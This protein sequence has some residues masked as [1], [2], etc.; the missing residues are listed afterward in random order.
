M[1]GQ[2]ETDFSDE[3]IQVTNAILQD[4]FPDL[5]E[6]ATFCNQ[7]PQVIIFRKINILINSLIAVFLFSDLE[8]FHE[9]LWYL[10]IICNLG[11]AFT[12]KPR[13]W[14]YGRPDPKIPKIESFFMVAAVGSWV[15][16]LI[17]WIGLMAFWDSRVSFFKHVAGSI[18]LQIHLVLIFRYWP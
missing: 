18:L 12:L 5:G 4:S 1:A 16:C 14:V 2:T 11:L 7:I 13:I 17:S 6:Y 8:L 3:D 9:K 15:I 10:I